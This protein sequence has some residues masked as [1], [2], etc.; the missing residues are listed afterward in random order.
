MIDNEQM[1]S[2]I[3]KI[4]EDS[5]EKVNK[6][7]YRLNYHIMPPVGFLNDPNGFIQ[8][9]GEYHLFYQFNPF[10]P[11]DKKVCWAHLRSK[12]L[13]T[14]EWLPIALFP[15]EWYETHGCYSGSAVNNN[16]IFTLIYTGNV[17]NSMG[18]RETY[19]CLAE[20]EDGIN[21]KKYIDN[22]VIYNQ[23][24]GYTRHFRDPKVWKHNNL[25]YTVIGAQTEEKQGTT[26]LYSSIDLIEWSKIG[27]LDSLMKDFG[28]MWECPNLFSIDNK[29]VLL[30]CPQGVKSKGDLYNNRYQC[31]YF[32]GKIDYETGK[33]KHDEFLEIDRGFEFYAPQVTVDDS[34]RTLM[35]GWIGLPDEEDSKTKENNWIHCLSIIR[36][37]YIKDN[38]LCQ[39]P[40]KEM[41]FLRKKLIQYSDLK[42]NS[43]NFE[44]PNNGDSYEMICDFAFEDEVVFGLRLRSKDGTDGTN[45]YY[46]SKNE[47]ITFDRENVVSA[48]RET[49]KCYIRNSRKLKL[50]IFMDKSSVEVFVN[51]GQETFTARIYP[52][53]NSNRIFIFCKN[54][55]VTVNIKFWNII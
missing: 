21:F 30:F 2:K 48:K 36:E 14:W 22:P 28:Y 27:E 32:I 53:K 23:P 19:Q 33:F 55:N 5:K 24:K 12:D 13:I 50:H 51:D 43:D 52:D 6:D 7:Y 8:I 9:N 38:K 29:D 45:V 10:Y 41:E 16:G 1:I 37:L 3:Y 17:K 47:K 46:D 20:S 34:G 31:G 42:I 25:W 44:L 40:I 35:V 54:G 15:M 39:R 26:L 4:I 18:V 49:R 11:E